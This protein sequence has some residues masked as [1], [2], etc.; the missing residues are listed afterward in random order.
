MDLSVF[1]NLRTLLFRIENRNKVPL[2]ECYLVTLESLLVLPPLTFTLAYEIY[3][4]RHKYA[5]RPLSFIVELDWSLLEA[6]L[7]A[8]PR[9]P[10]SLDFIFLPYDPA[11]ESPEVN[12]IAQ[13]EDAIRPR[14]PVLNDRGLLSFRL[15]RY[16]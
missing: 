14:L 4:C 16:L 2:A 12:V 10:T 9:L 8:L 3:P 6:R 5:P 1:T 11:S 15:G 7:L 13:L